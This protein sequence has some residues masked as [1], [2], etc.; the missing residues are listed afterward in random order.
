MDRR[1]IA[2]DRLHVALTVT[3]TA[4]ALALAAWIVL[5]LVLP[6]PTQRALDACR[7]VPLPA[8]DATTF[9][10]N[11]PDCVIVLWH[12]TIEGVVLEPKPPLTPETR[13][14]PL[15][16]Q[17]TARAAGYQDSCG[18]ETN[19]R[20]GWLKHLPP[21]DM[22][23]PLSEAWIATIW[24]RGKAQQQARALCVLIQS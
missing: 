3:V 21:V 20:E 4:I 7:K 8:V 19:D 12:Q 9:D 5:S 1:P 16:L 6:H 23:L 18:S 2:R 10:P 13:T 22:T 17:T 24:T 14:L 11:A 15:E